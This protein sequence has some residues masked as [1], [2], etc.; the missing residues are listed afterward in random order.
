MLPLKP[1]YELMTMKTRFTIK[2]APYFLWMPVPM[3]TYGKIKKEFQALGKPIDLS[4]GMIE[5]PKMIGIGYVGLPDPEGTLEITG[6]FVAYKM[7][8][9]YAQFKTVWGQ[10]MKDY[11]KISEGY[12]LYKTDPDVTPKEENI[13]YILIR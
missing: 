13:T 4:I 5:N 11:P 2:K 10:I 9:D 6:D 1:G 8:G 12:H 7:V 3:S